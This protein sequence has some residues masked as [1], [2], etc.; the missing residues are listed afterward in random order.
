MNSALVTWE[1]VYKGGAIDREREGALYAG[2]DRSLLSTFR[3]VAPGEILVEMPIVSPRTG[4]NLVYRRR[5][6]MN[7]GQ[8]H[9]WFVVGFMPMGPVVA[10]QPETEQIMKAEKFSEG[11]GPLGQI[12]PTPNEKWLPS[13]TTDVRLSS[14]RIVL[15]S[16]YKLGVS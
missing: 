15:P 12:Q 1:A 5:T 10:I 9:V 16:G 3:I 11:A 14:Q 13:H 2:I 4:H 6:I 8:R 7:R